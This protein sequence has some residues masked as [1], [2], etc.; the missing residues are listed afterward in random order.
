MNSNP[1][2]SKY[3]LPFTKKSSIF[4]LQV[5]NLI[6]AIGEDASRTTVDNAALL[7]PLNDD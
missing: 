6:V 4:V 3:H 2:G 1:G 7:T 5:K